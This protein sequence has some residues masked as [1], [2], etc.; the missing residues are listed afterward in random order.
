MKKISSVISIVR[1]TVADELHHKSF[2]ALLAV[3]V[4]LI[5]ALRGCYRSGY[6]VNGRRLDGIAVAWHTALAAYHAVAVFGLFAAMIFANRALRRDRDNG[7]ARFILSRPVSRLHYC[8]GKV[9]G[10]WIIAFAFMFLLHAAVFFM[11]LTVGGGTLPLLPV[12]SLA[13]GIN[14]A[15]IV[16]LFC[17]LSTALAEFASL[18][19]G[20]AVVG[21]S[22]ISD[23]IHAVV[24]SSVVQSAL[25]PAGSPQTFTASWWRIA[26]PKVAALQY[27]GASLIKGEA[28]VTMGPIHPLAN[29][30]I[31]AVLLFAILVWRIERE[32]L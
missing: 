27:Y 20:A 29:V 7:T 13:C 22:F 16:C 15:F 5:I 3:C 9:I 31:Y 12:A 25:L 19:A 26:W 30:A 18:A 1:F 11:T 6:V 17:L 10:T 21:V 4:L 28:F 32:E 8:A 14:L 23:S 2:F 24:H